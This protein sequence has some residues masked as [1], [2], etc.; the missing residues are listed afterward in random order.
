MNNSLSI[1][2]QCSHEYYMQC[3]YSG[4]TFQFIVVKRPIL[5]NAILDT[6]WLDRVRTAG[7][8]FKY[9]VDRVFL[10][11]SQHWAWI[12]VKQEIRRQ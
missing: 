7:F 3:L 8:V 4:S 1:H 5:L 2:Q 9:N 12:Y 6:M 11:S 10:F